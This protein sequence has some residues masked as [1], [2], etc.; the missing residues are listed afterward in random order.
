MTVFHRFRGE[1]GRI[2]FVLSTGRLHKQS[3][4]P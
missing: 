4:S 3:F 1:N 2:V